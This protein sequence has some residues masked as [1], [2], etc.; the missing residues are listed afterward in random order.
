MFPA[1]AVLVLAALLQSHVFASHQAAY[2]VPTS[3]AP[4][5]VSFSPRPGYF[6]ATGDDTI[7]GGIFC[8]SLTDLASYLSLTGDNAGATGS[9]SP[10]GS[11]AVTSGSGPYPAQMGTD[12]SLP[13]H[14]IYAPKTPPP[15]DVSL[16]FISFAEGAC[17]ETGTAYR[18]FL[19]EI[20]SW[21]YVIAADGSPGGGSGQSKVQESRDAINWAVSGGAKKYGNVSAEDITSMGHSCGGLEAMSVAYHDERVKRIVLLDIAIF[22]DDRRYLLK[23]L[24]VPVSWFVGGPKDMGYPNVSVKLY[25]SDR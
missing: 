9:E 13:G 3:V 25:E 20:A 15:D 5:T 2:A 7:A 18:N 16:P 11:G 1:G 23:E 12:A 19:T 14:T 17:M 4:P 6:P 21:G 10:T 24:E 8:L 22:Q